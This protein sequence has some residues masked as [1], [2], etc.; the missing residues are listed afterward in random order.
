MSGGLFWAHDLG[1]R[2]I[3]LP[4]ILHRILLEIH[5]N[6]A[7]FYRRTSLCSVC[8]SMCLCCM[9]LFTYNCMRIKHVAVVYMCMY[10]RVYV[11]TCICSFIHVHTC[12]YIYAHIYTR[13]CCM[14]VHVC[15][16]KCAAGVQCIRA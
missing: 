9:C 3:R 4:P 12:I 2:P 7:S 8:T 1:P 11:Y 6:L 15:V 16:C 10:V 5:V 14:H 13:V